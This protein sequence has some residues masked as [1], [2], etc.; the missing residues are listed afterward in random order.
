M[1]APCDPARPYRCLSRVALPIV[2][3]VTVVLGVLVGLLW[4]GAERQD[5]IARARSIEIVARIVDDAIAQMA[6]EAKDY[7]WWNDAVRAL[8]MEV[9]PVWADNNIGAYVHESFGYEFGFVVDE[10]G[11]TRYASID[12]ARATAD[13]FAHLGNGLE[14]LID[15]TREASVAYRPVPAGGL[16][17]SPRGPV[18]AGASLVTPEAEGDLDLPSGRSAVVVFAEV[19]DAGFWQEFAARY[20]LEGFEVQPPGSPDA[21]LPLVAVDGT[22]L[23]GLVWQPHHPGA[24]YFR[25]VLPWVAGATVLVALVTALV[26]RRT[27]RTLIESEAR[28]RD[29]ANATSDWIWE[30]DAA[31]R[32][33]FVSE[34]FAE[35][36]EIAVGRILGRPLGDMLVAVDGPE[37]TSLSGLLAAPQPFRNLLCRY[38]DR[39]GTARIVRLAGTPIFDA[40]GALRGHRGTATDV[41]REVEAER[42]VRFLALHDPLTGLANRAGLHRRLERAVADT[43]RRG[44]LA[45]VICLDLDRFKDINDTLGHTAGDLLIKHVGERLQACVREVDTVARLGGDEFA[46]VQVGVRGP[47]DVETLCRRILAAVAEPVDL[48]GNEVMVTASLGIALM[49]DDGGEPGRLLQNADIALFRTKD[50]GGDG[51]RFFEPRMDARLRE[52]KALEQD[53]RAA[54]HGDELELHYQPQFAVDDRRLVGVEALLRWHHP[55]RGAVPPAAFVPVAEESGLMLP[56]GE[57]VLRAACRQAAGWPGIV[58]SVNL[59][60]VQFRHRD[61]VTIVRAALDDSGLEPGRLELEVTEAVLL[62]DGEATLAKLRALQALG[63]RISMDDFGTGCSHLC[64][65]HQFGFDK[66]KIDQCFVQSMAAREDAGAIVR[67]VMVLGRS[68]GM[69]IC[70]E[71]VETAE[72]LAFLAAEGCDQ[73]QGFYFSEALRADEISVRYFAGGELTEPGLLLS[74][75]RR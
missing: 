56:L 60:P 72:Q 52:R 46:V 21:M 22:P 64:H 14:Q 41:T 66:L 5:A 49:P 54:L 34:R 6:R 19:L 8:V 40:G 7:A 36:T 42:Q 29:V 57:W 55:E 50:E 31:G 17:H 20:G 75:H 63:V 51:I 44:E 28:F 43:L 74:E 67:A 23:G 33:T 38:E 1:A 24:A 73:V 12:G 48:D 2:G 53:L 15:Q 65:L 68:L 18:V 13:A 30:T 32:L 62:R 35:A 59:S 70:A 39:A 9:D 26:L 61:L 27:T 47:E 37:A 69:Q 45:A 10:A 58:M 16:L 25:A 11:G 3:L 4:Y 71:G